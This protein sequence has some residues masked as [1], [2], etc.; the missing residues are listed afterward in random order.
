M[1]YFILQLSCW[2]ILDLL[3]NYYCAIFFLSSS[4]SYDP[5]SSL[6]HHLFLLLHPLPPIP[7]LHFLITS[8]TS[9]LPHHILFLLLLPL[10]FFPHKMLIYQCTM[11]RII[12]IPENFHSIEPLLGIIK[13][14]NTMFQPTHSSAFI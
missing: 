10:F 7:P 5:P 1:E 14:V 13:I 6:P 9:S 8:T 3:C 11:R 4:L 2:E 12:N